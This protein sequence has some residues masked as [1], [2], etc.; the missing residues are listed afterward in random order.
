[1]YV[2]L[3][4][5]KWCI[6]VA[7]C[8]GVVLSAVPPKK[9]EVSHKKPVSSETTLTT[10]TRR[11]TLANDDISRL[12]LKL[13]TLKQDSI[14]ALAEFTA[15][16]TL[17]SSKEELL[18]AFLAR[19]NQEISALHMEY[20]QAQQD[21]SALAGKLN[22]Q[23]KDFSPDTLKKLQKLEIMLDGLSAQLVQQQHDFDVTSHQL[24]S[25]LQEKKRAETGTLERMASIERKKQT[26][27]RTLI[28]QNG[29]CAKLTI[30]QQDI[31]KKLKADIVR[32]DSIIAS[33]EGKK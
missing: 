17:Y 12:T 21:S 2:N 11:I 6:V 4:G 14:H 19:I 27:L 33:V 32:L 15:S 3:S 24:D 5:S 29:I 10:I 18:Q 22:I 30:Q 26:T 8:I 9:T 7:L 13:D 16:S 28:N 25:L 23:S 1:M 20:T 31:L